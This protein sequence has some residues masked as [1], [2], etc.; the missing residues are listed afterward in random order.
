MDQSF[1]EQIIEL[2]KIARVADKDDKELA[3]IL[4][5]LVKHPGWVAYQTLLGR[6]IQMF[7][8]TVMAPAGSNDGAIAL[9]WVKGAMSGLLIARNLPSVIIDAMK[10]K[11]PAT[12]GDDD[13]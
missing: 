3:E 7:A 13:A 10:P 4:E 11:A 6:R 8:D 2:H 1:R 12:D 9:E 5:G